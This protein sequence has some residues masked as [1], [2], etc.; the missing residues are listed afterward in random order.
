[1]PVGGIIVNRVHEPLLSTAALKAAAAGTLDAAGLAR[2]LKLA[3][4]TAEDAVTSGLLAEAG[5]HARLLAIERRLRAKLR[6]SGRPLYDLP[7][8]DTTDVG[9]LYAL[10]DALINQGAA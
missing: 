9:R 2:G 6:A 5:D 7:D 4:V 1:L 3:G 10:A 8:L